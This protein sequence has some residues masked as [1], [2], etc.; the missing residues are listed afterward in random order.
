MERLWTKKG[1]L[2]DRGPEVSRAFGTLLAKFMEAHA[3]T[4][5]ETLD[6]QSLMLHEVFFRCA[7]R[8]LKLME[9]RPRRG[10]GKS[11]NS[12]KKG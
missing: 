5:Y 10:A 2:T 12:R 7:M 4:G 11:R 8:R 6:L 9:V 1:Q 3:T